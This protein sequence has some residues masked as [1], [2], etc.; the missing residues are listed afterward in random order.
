[1]KIGDLVRIKQSTIRSYH[2]D[3]LKRIARQRIPML[4]IEL[5]K[6][7]STEWPQTCMLLCDGTK[8][9]LLRESLTQQGMRQ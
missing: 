7:S 3:C 1:M 2:T 8:F 6:P 5:S 4:I 9:D